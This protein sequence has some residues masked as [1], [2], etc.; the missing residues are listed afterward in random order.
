MTYAVYRIYTEDLANVREYVRGHFESCTLIRGQGVW[1][2]VKENS[3]IVEVMLPDTTLSDEHIEYTA[4]AI[5]SLAAQ[6]AVLTTKQPQEVK[7]V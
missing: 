4:K 5:K 1:K 2:R 3:L 6:Q 7:L